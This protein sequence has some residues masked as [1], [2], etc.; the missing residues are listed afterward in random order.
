MFDLVLCVLTV[1]FARVAP[2]VT[3]TLDGR[4]TAFVLLLESDTT[5]PPEGAAPL[6]VTVPVDELPPRTLV[7]LSESDASV[8]DADDA[9]T[10]LVHVCPAAHV[11]QL[12]VPPQPSEALPQSNPSEEH[13][14]GVQAPGLIVRFSLAEELL[15]GAEA[16]TVT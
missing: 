15:Q 10:L 1:K 2:A 16:D 8:T 4:V 9:Q 12:S 13:V 7:G 11:P 6:S 5:A 14:A 3:V